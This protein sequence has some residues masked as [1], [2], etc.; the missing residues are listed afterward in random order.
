MAPVARFFEAT[1]F[2][3][4]LFAAVVIARWCWITL[5]RDRHGDGNGPSPWRELYR[6]A[7]LEQDATKIAVRIEA[8]E[9]AILLALSRQLFRPHD[10]EW[11]ALQDAMNNLRAL[12]KNADLQVETQAARKDP[13]RSTPR[14]RPPHSRGSWGT[15]R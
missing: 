4:W 2:L 11:R 9:G 6:M 14:S 12:R 8:A 13:H 7:L 10:P 1:W 3:W 15:V 5:V